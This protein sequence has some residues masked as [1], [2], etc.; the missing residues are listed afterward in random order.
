VRTIGTPKKIED[1]VR[2]ACRATPRAIDVGRATFKDGMTRHFINIAGLGFDALVASRA[3]RTKFLPGANLPYLVAALRTLATYRN[4][5]VTIEVDGETISTYAVFVQVAN[6]KYMGGG[7]KIVP[8]ADIEDGLLD[9]AIVA[10][11]TKPDLLRTLPRVYGGG[12]VNHPKFRHI[13]AKQ[14]RIET[15]E[16]ALVQLDGE[17]AGHAPAT[18]EVVPA[19]LMLAG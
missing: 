6:A 19:G 4:I 17:I 14:V 8:G 10:D 13:R 11:L 1:A 5:K 7:Y 15:V 12:H 16:P 2:A 9:L 3:P 18:F